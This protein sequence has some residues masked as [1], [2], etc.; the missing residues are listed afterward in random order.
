MKKYALAISIIGLCIQGFGIGFM[1]YG[2]NN[3][4]SFTWIGSLIAAIGLMLGAV[5]LIILAMKKKVKTPHNTGSY[6]K[7]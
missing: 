1:L 2:V 4:E 6:E 3:N 7:P 5:G